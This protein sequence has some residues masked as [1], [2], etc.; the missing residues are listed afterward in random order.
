MDGNAVHY[1]AEYAMNFKASLFPSLLLSLS[2]LLLSSAVYAQQSVPSSASCPALPADAVGSLQWVTLQT[3]TALLC[4]AVRKD[5]GLEAFALTLTRKSP[6]KPDSGL[7]EE[8]GRI[9]GKKMWWYRSE[10]AG[11][12]HEL[13][14]ETLLKLDS[15]GV[16]HA[17]IRTGDASELTR[18]QQV[19]QALDF[20]A[21]S[22]AVR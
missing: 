20:A 11:R 8:E 10:I 7:R 19:I 1:F 6:F 2:S 14:R 18:Y 21:P 16:A 13:V 9:Q 17:Y 22:V 4:R 5:D 3:D 12:P 15:G